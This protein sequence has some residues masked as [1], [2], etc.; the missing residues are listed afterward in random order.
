[1]IK[2]LTV[3]VAVQVPSCFELA[4]DFDEVWSFDTLKT[5]EHRVLAVRPLWTYMEEEENE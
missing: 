4:D 1:M 3:S 2:I 5:L